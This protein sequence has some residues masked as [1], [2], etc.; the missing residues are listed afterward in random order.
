MKINGMYHSV[1]WKKF[2]MACVQG[3]P[4]GYKFKK[5][6]IKNMYKCVIGTEKH[7]RKE[8]ANSH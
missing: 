4:E 8:L 5:N 1:D 2:R 7:K 6:E 3:A